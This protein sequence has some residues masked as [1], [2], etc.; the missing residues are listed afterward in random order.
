M[1]YNLCKTQ[2]Y[3]SKNNSSNNQKQRFRA[4]PSSRC[5]PKLDKIIEK[6]LLKSLS[7]SQ[8]APRKP[9]TLLQKLHLRYSSRIQ[10][11]L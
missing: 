2:L 4:V 1:F 9:A 10:L 8:V 7:L 3:N 5:S 6:Y 11:K